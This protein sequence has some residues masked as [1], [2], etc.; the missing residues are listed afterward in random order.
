MLSTHGLGPSGVPLIAV[1]LASLWRVP[2]RI[3]CPTHY[4]NFFVALRESGNVASYSET[5]AQPTKG[6]R[7]TVY[8]MRAWRGTAKRTRL[9]YH[10]CRY[11]P[12][13]LTPDLLAS[14]GPAHLYE[15]PLPDLMVCHPDSSW[16]S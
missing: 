11:L 9:E 12:R 3:L 13:R 1:S 8:R 15:N 2:F 6:Y 10:R 14:Q 7:E 5:E 16:G 4:A